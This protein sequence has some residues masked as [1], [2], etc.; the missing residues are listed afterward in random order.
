MLESCVRIFIPVQNYVLNT[1]D[2]K[3]S[4]TTRR[5]GYYL[6]NARY[7][8]QNMPDLMETDKYGMK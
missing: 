6:K 2:A 5:K 8:F 4:K 3:W 1:S 7:V